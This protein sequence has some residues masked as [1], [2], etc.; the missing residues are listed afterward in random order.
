MKKGLP[1]PKQNATRIGLF[2]S[3]LDLNLKFGTKAFY[4]AKTS[5]LRK[6]DKK[7]LEWF[8]MLRRSLGP[9]M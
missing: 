6:V 3:K 4:D 7:C 2:T 9:I 8:E 1:W 5:T